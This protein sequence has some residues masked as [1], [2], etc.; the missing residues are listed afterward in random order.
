MYVSVDLLGPLVIPRG[1]DRAR[2][3]RTSDLS[4]MSA[5]ALLDRVWLCLSIHTFLTF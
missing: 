2:S 5:D 3:Q 4:A 1:V